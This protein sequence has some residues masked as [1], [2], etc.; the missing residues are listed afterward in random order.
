MSD[1]QPEFNRFS[2]EGDWAA[3][4]ALVTN[5]V[6]DT[7][8]ISGTPN[9]VV[10]KLLDRYGNIA[11]RISP[12]VYTAYNVVAKAMADAMKKYWRRPTPTWF[13][14]KPLAKNARRIAELG[15]GWI[16]IVQDPDEI[17]CG[18][19]ILHKVFVDVGRKPEELAVRAISSFVSTTGG[20]PDLEATLSGVQAYI[21]AGATCL[22][23]LP[24]Y[25]AQQSEQLEGVFR[26][27]ASV[28]C[29]G[30]S[31]CNHTG[32]A[33]EGGPYSIAPYDS[34]AFWSTLPVVDVFP[35]G[36]EHWAADSPH[37]LLFTAS[38]SA[39]VTTSS[40]APHRLIVVRMAVSSMRGHYAG[41]VTSST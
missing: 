23:F 25:F 19:E 33:S 18:I 4:F 26:A 14:L 5:E 36:V 3:M 35:I 13:G 10:R 41:L 27:V 11:Q 21:D 29:T 17:A 20:L 22:E 12:V 1:L 24:L 38:V 37:S 15:D 7:L 39:S 40:C 8:A 30:L 31:V 34:P 28:K 6:L 32:V 2:K 16:P 9:E